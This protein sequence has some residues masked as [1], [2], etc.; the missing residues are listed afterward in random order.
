VSVCTVYG[1]YHTYSVPTGEDGYGRR[2]ECGSPQ[3]Y[4]PSAGKPAV[5]TDVLVE[6][7]DLRHV[8]EDAVALLD[9]HGHDADDDEVVTRLYALLD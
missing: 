8:L 2:C 4:K 7:E 3:R 6:A 1:P 9:L 5:F